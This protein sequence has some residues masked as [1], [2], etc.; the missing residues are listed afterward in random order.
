MIREQCPVC[1]A[2][3]LME[4]IA[5]EEYPLAGNGA[6]KREK[7]DE[8]PTGTLSVG[9]CRVCG[10]LFQNDPVSVEALDGMLLRQP[11]PLP[12]DVTGMETAETDRF[13]EGLRR[14]GPSGGRVL[15]IGCGT[16]CLL[17]RLSER[18]FG[19]AGVDAHPEAAAQARE[20]GFEVVE[21]RFEEGMF[22]EESFDLVIARSVLE[23]VPEPTMLLSAMADLLKPGGVVALEVPNTGRVFRRSAYGGFAFHHVNYWTTPTLRYLVTLE[24]LDVVGGF[25]ESYIALFARK[26][27]RGQAGVD[28]VPPGDETVEGLLEEAEA[29]L[30]RKEALAEELP[31]VVHDSFPGGIVV[32]GAGAPTVDMLYYTGLDSE[33]VHVVS[34]DR[35]RFGAVLAGTKHEIHPMEVLEEANFDGILISSERRQDEL[36]DRL[37][38]YRHGGGRVIRFHPGIEMI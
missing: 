17:R 7:A 28:P 10:A 21:G 34:S 6:V 29:F 37:S 33:I 31:R 36:L 9:F 13:L 26:A 16:G 24:G 35:T 25:E 3:D 2:S 32:L 38:A 4:L 18:G 15:D 11:G 22:P 19:V 5:L 1:G 20:A 8:V 23:H 27:E 12:M 14:Y 30:E